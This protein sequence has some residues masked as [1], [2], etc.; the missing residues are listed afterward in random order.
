MN[1]FVTNKFPLRVNKFF[2]GTNMGTWKAS[3]DA[4][5]NENTQ[6]NPPG[7]VQ[8]FVKKNKTH[9]ERHVVERERQK[10]TSFH[11]SH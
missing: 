10:S 3:D 7:I 8:V 11:S 6:I 1:S 9:R 4:N 2:P 5:K